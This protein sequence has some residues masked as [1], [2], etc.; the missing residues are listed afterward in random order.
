[1]T[2]QN[3]TTKYIW[4]SSLS[5]AQARG[6]TPLKARNDFR[7]SQTAKGWTWRQ[8]IQQWNLKQNIEIVEGGTQGGGV[9]D[10]ASDGERWIEGNDEN[11]SGAREP[12][13][14]HDY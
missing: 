1:M 2:Q 13:L 7:D 4:D 8:F 11:I 12:E 5:T 14:D 3:S 10:Q 9:Q 6:L